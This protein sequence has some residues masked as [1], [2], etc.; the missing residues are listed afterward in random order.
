MDE[1]RRPIIAELEGLQEEKAVLEKVT[2][3]PYMHVYC[4]IS[5]FA[6]SDTSR[7]GR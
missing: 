7:K 2:D 3:K 1:F 5:Y 6:H 4:G